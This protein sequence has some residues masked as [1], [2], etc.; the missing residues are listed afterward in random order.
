M[1]SDLLASPLT[2]LHFI[3]CVQVHGSQAPDSRDNSHGGTRL[4]MDYS[5]W[6]SRR[7]MRPSPGGGNAPQDSYRATS[8]NFASENAKAEPLSDGAQV[9]V[10]A[11]FHPRP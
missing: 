5:A 11:I 3:S 10:R 7:K 1:E 6:A 4:T 9:R 8:L 2:A